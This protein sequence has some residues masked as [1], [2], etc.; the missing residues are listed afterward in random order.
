MRMSF[1]LLFS[2][3]RDSFCKT[4][5]QV[6]TIKIGFSSFCTLF[7]QIQSSRAFYDAKKTEG[8]Y[9]KIMI[10]KVITHINKRLEIGSLTM[11]MMSTQSLS[12]LLPTSLRVSFILE[13]TFVMC[14]WALSILFV[15]CSS[16]AFCRR[17]SSP[18]RN[19]SSCRSCMPSPISS[20]SLSNS[21]SR[22][23]TIWSCTC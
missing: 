7:Q 22:S 2:S 14:S 12:E 20:R 21:A 11:H 1:E 16:M 8:R 9:Q 6:R 3:S 5:S 23:R 10:C 13:F 15:V 19:A 4:Y 18:C 17:T